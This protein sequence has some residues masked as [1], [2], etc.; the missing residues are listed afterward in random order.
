MNKYYGTPVVELKKIEQVKHFLASVICP[1]ANEPD[2]DIT[3]AEMDVSLRQL[4]SDTGWRLSDFLGYYAYFYEYMGVFDTS[5]N[6]YIEALD[7]YYR[8]NHLIKI[9]N[10]WEDHGSAWS[11]KTNKHYLWVDDT[12]RQYVGGTIYTFHPDHRADISRGEYPFE[13]HDYHPEC[14]RR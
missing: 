10:V 13:N 6:Y 2:A 12:G 7:D 1:C 3:G 8:T 4:I 9:L 14:R 11:Y 5:A